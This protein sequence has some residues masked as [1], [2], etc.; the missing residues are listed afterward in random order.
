M[1]L[2]KKKKLLKIS[3]SRGSKCGFSKLWIYQES[4]LEMFGYCERRDIPV[5][6]NGVFKGL[7][8][9]FEIACAG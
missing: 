6:N 9:E 3:W 7:D 4:Y 2:K 8:T 5:A 1:R